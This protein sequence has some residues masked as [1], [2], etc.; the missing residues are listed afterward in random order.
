MNWKENLDPII[1]QHLE[2][3]IGE[4]VKYKTTYNIS[5][6]PGNAQLWI[7][8]AN[9]S[10]ELFEISLRLKHLEGILKKIEGKKEVKK[11]ITKR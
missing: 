4:T 7:A 2:R 9:L 6:N 3:Q 5:S 8:I 11:K 10:K 1:R